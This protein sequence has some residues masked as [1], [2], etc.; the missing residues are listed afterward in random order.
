MRP[1]HL[2]MSA[3]GPYA[4]V[5]ALDFTLLGERGLYLITGDTGAGKTT[6]FDAI[7][8]ALY[9][10][11]SGDNRSPAMLRS[12]YAAPERETYVELRF[13]YHGKEYTVRRSPEYDRPKQ[14]G[15]G[16]TSQKAEAVLSYPDERALVGWRAV[17]EAVEKEIMGITRAQFV[18]VAMIA[19]GD[20][21]RLLLAKTEERQDIFRR[22]FNTELYQVFQD[23]LKRDA[24]AL[25]ARQRELGRGI[26]Q[27][28]NGIV[29]DENKPLTP[30]PLPETLQLLADI[31]TRDTELLRENSAALAD[32][33]KQLEALNQAIGKAQQDQRARAALHT[34]E[35]SLP[36]QLRQRAD[37][38][39]LLEK[40]RARQPERDGLQKSIVQLEAVLPKFEQLRRLRTQLQS[41][42]EQYRR[43]SE[44]SSKARAEYE[45]LYKAYLDAHAGILAR[46]LVPGTP[47]PVCGAT[48][49]PCPAVLQG[50]APDRTA[51]KQAKA[52]AARMEREAREA[53]DSAAALLGQV[54]A[55]EAEL[56][57]P[58]PDEASALLREQKR[59]KTE[60]E[61]ALTGAQMALDKLNAAVT[62]TQSQIAT[63]RQQLE[64]TQPVDLN[65]LREKKTACQSAQA[66]L[67]GQNE[68][69]AVRRRTNAA[70][71]KNISA[72]AAALRDVEERLKW[73]KALSDTAN[74]D[75]AG[76]EKLKLETYIQIAYFDRIIARANTR[77]MVMTGA[78]YEL[79]RRGA[80]GRQS[81]SGLDL[82]V[83]D[84]YNG[85]RR[86]VKTLSGGESFM[87]S[88]SLAL[89]LSDE[90]QSYA[91]G[92]RLD[93]MFIDEGFGSLDESTLSQAM[94]ALLGVAESNRLVGIISHVG[95]MKEKIDRQIVVT[96]ERAG[97]S[98]ARIVV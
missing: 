34:A 53:S 47:C 4:E 96:K 35:S 94:R 84:H 46:A 89:G 45:R 12:K 91:G 48:E 10:E 87:A 61:K 3:F 21:L 25:A 78:Q 5:C 57:G 6:I 38:L 43:I 54:S 55:K 40:E 52:T 23:R 72:G 66:Q 29:Y 18:Q 62:G 85:T 64:N 11:A 95:E 2:T 44:A 36:E 77:L 28:V 22:I 81:Q 70:V 32:F 30:Q 27:Y 80:A 65:A 83:T 19:Q 60:L 7:A 73:M 76:K 86:D 51:L 16:L 42:Q 88:L 98:R 67:T 1:L 71:Q 75:I 8:F 69:I 41:A 63:L 15:A 13:A 97:G 50:N 79:K 31:N 39:A 20:F 49:H 82:D 26:E 33:A 93:A 92:I 24:N 74:G 58:C 9:G 56:T 14:R 17:T 90:I 68:N 37:A 59:K